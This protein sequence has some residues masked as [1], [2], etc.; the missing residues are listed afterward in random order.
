MPP[1]LTPETW[2]QI[3]YEYEHTEK[4]VDDICL[5][6]G[7]SP[8]TLRERMRRWRWT[9]RRQPISAEGPPPV[10]PNEYAGPLVPAAAPI[11]APAPSVWVEAHDEPAPDSPAPYAAPREE[12]PPGQSEIVPRLQSAVARVLP[13]IEATV[14]RLAGP[15]PPR[16]MERAARTLTSLTRTLRE[17]NGLLSQ[18]P[19][20]PDPDNERG[21]DD[22]DEFALDLLRRLNEFAA[23]RAASTAAEN[24]TAGA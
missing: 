23:S 10:L 8:T 4:P 15:M 24:E 3:R 13:A 22:P 2:M 12:P 9:R 7:V 20:P 16:E 11:R 1:E 21:P 14:A 17:L 19:A 6:H 5:D 18:Y